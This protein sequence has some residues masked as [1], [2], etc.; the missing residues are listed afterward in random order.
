MESG[1]EMQTISV[2]RQL[3]RNSRIIKP[4]R[5]AAIK[6][7][8]T[9]PLMEARTK[10]DWSASAVTFSS[11]VTLARILGSASFTA[12]DDG[13]RGCLA[14]ARDGH[15]HA[16]RSVGAHDIVL[17]RIAVVHLRDIFYI[18]RRAIDGFDGQ[19]IQIVA[20]ARGLLLTRT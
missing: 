16:A 1:M 15:Q 12:F 13:Q 10:T 3:P 20:G 7:S 9:T 5:P 19:V 6:A 17:H 2:L 8:R 11:G 4:V 14:V 18:D